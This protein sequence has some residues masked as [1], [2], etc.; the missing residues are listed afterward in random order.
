M[1]PAIAGQ[2]TTCRYGALWWP[3]S[4]LTAARG[5]ARRGVAFISLVPVLG[6]LFGAIILHEMLSV[7]DGVA[8]ISISLGV[9]LAAEGFPAPRRSSAESE[10]GGRRY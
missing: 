7:I 5:H 4:R 8:V 9:L 2:A 6:T 10:G 3:S 1:L